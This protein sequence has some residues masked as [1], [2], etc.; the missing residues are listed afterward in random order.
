MPNA[1]ACA[2]AKANLA[3]GAI[4]DARATATEAA[5]EGQ[6]H[7]DTSLPPRK[8]LR[9]TP[10]VPP[11]NDDLAECL[12]QCESTQRRSILLERAQVANR[13]QVATVTTI[14]NEVAGEFADAPRN[15][16]MKLRQTL[17]VSDAE[18]ENEKANGEEDEE[19]AKQKAKTKS[20][21]Q[22][23]GQSKDR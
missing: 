3:V 9:A 13:A 23:K 7:A 18:E 12:L 17:N 14:T 8:E 21:G 6:A 20:Q 19:E 11:A 1:K 10:R 2:T 5:A 22:S 4:S 16:Q 15:T